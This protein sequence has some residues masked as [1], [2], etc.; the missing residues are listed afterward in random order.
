MEYSIIIYTQLAILT[1]K[2]I[3][4]VIL[5]TSFTFSEIKEMAECLHMYYI[6]TTYQEVC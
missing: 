4:S 3:F 6:W 1:E 5:G 2:D